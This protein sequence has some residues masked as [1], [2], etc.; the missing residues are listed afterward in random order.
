[1]NRLFGTSAW[2]A[3]AR[4]LPVVI[5]LLAALGMACRRPAPSETETQKP[6]TPEASAASAAVATD[7][8]VATGTSDPRDG[9]IATTASSPTPEPPEP[10]LEGALFTKQVQAAFRVAG[11]GGDDSFIPAHIDKE[12]VDAHCATLTSSYDEYRREWL[13]VAVPFIA[14]LRPAELPTTVVYPF[15][16]GDL[17]SALATFPDAT[18]ITTISLEIAGDVRAIDKADKKRLGSELTQL[19]DHLGKL[20]LKAHSRTVNLDI[21]THGAI[22][23]E[24]AYTMA[25]L[26]IHGYEPITLRYFAFAPDGSVEWLTEE[27]IAKDHRRGRQGPFANAEIR[28]RKRGE[29]KVRALRHVAF[30]LSDGSL[31]SAPFLLKHLKAKGKVAAMTKAASYLLWDDAHFSVIRDYLMKN[32]DW[33]ISDTTGVPPRIAKKHGFVQDVYGAF[34]RPEPFGP[35]NNADAKAYSDLFKT[36]TPISFRYGYPDDK[37]RG[38]IVVTRKPEVVAKH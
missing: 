31:R 21:E 24:V 4:R 36:A 18:E 7:A 19:R 2:T 10:A 35:V 11:C 1:M 9:G 22:P 26:V 27:A 6:D 30:D 13:D 15:G 5:A 32:T 14:K 25:A 37:S 38:H 28:F 3:S 16:G 34:E 29:S 8:A 23:G 12:L 20:F 17:V 33:M